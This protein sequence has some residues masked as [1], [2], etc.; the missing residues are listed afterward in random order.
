MAIEAEG[1]AGATSEEGEED[2]TGEGGE[3]TGGVG[4]SEEVSEIVMMGKYH[5]F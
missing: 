1:V 2:L 3:V 4:P 5:S